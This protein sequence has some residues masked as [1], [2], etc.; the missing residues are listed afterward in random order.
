M[1]AG[2][3]GSRPSQRLGEQRSSYQTGG[4]DPCGQ[5]RLPTRASWS[6]VWL[7]FRQGVET[8]GLGHEAAAIWLGRQIKSDSSGIIDGTEV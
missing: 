8:Q 5:P 3:E 1:E 6:P 7:G 4:P 2:G